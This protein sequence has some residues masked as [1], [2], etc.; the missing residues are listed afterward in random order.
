MYAVTNQPPPLEPY[1][2][3]QTDRVLAAALARENAGWAAAALTALGKTLGEAETNRLGFLANINPPVLHAFDLGPA[4]PQVPSSLI[5]EAMALQ[6]K[7]GKWTKLSIPYPMGFMTRSVNWRIDDPKAGWKGKIL[8]APY[9]GAAM[10][11][12]ENGALS[13]VASFQMRP[14]P[15]AH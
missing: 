2:L 15:L 12:Q 10:G 4:S 11:H 14:N 7:T 6:P 13:H 5:P 9:A 3:L 1:N 8:W